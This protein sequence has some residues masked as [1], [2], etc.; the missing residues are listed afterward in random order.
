M[1]DPRTFREGVLGGRTSLTGFH[2]EATDGDAGRV[3]WGWYEPGDSFLVLTTGWLRKTHHLLP[4]GAV[5]SV[6][7]GEV[8]VTLSR[9]EID[10]L[11]RVDYPQKVQLNDIFYA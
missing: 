5:T 6:R 3:S 10:H 9:T 1:D 2:V 8:R 7:D 4:A 11:P